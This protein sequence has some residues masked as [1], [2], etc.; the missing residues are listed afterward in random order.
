LN[1]SPRSRPKIEL[2]VLLEQLHLAC[3]AHA[4]RLRRLNTFL[5]GH[6]LVMGSVAP[7]D[8]AEAS[9]GLI[10]VAKACGLLE[11]RAGGGQPT[12]EATSGSGV[13]RLDLTSNPPPWV[14]PRQ[15]AGPG[16]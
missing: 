15:D 11:Q 9:A 12:I 5:L 7:E 6:H 8:R 4:G 16:G 3:L 10:R 2:H 1:A 14:A 13:I